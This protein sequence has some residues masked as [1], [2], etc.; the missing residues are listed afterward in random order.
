MTGFGETFPDR[1]H[2]WLEQNVKKT[3]PAKIDGSGEEALKAQLI[4]EAA[5]ESWEKGSIVNIR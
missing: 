5:I 2:V 4:I 3:T 1:L